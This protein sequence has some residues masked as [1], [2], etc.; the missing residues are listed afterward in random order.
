VSLLGRLIDRFS[1][2]VA[3]LGIPA[4][5]RELHELDLEVLRDSWS[6]L[7]QELRRALQGTELM[8]LLRPM[9][10]LPAN[11]L[12]RVDL[13]ISD[14]DL[15][16]LPW[17]FLQVDDHHLRR[18]LGLID[19]CVVVRIVGRPRYA[20]VPPARGGL[21]VL[22]ACSYES[23]EL[24]ADERTLLDDIERDLSGPRDRPKGRSGMVSLRGSCSW[25]KFIAALEGSVH[26][27]H[28]MAPISEQGG[29]MRVRFGRAGYY[30]WV[31]AAEVVDAF[32]RQHRAFNAVLVETLASRVGGGFEC[33][34]NVAEMLAIK[35]SGPVVAVCHTAQYAGLYAKI[36]AEADELDSAGPA[37]FAGRFFDLVSQEITVDQALHDAR[38]KAIQPLHT[39]RW[40][41]GIPVLFHT[42]EPSTTPAG[43]ASKPPGGPRPASAAQKPLPKIASGGSS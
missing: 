11:S 5:G 30:E 17:E 27:V 20:E 26:A 25:A 24:S 13:R 28:L 10:S 32:A 18:P 22:F 15:A 35:A 1:R 21:T 39:G 7:G 43:A 23:G 6:L 33:V 36:R 40:F 12:L 3:E 37:T 9:I 41:F 31:D 29:V 16:R 42:A 8:E 34:N 19:G 14:D 2:C 4:E 38:N